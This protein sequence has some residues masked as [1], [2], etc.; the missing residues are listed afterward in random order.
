MAKSFTEIVSQMTKSIKGVREAVLGKEVREHIASGMESEL[1]IY[2]QLNTAVEEVK[3][4]I[5]KA[6]DPTLTLS[7]KA[8]DAK[9]TGA[10]VDKLED[11]KAD[12]TDLDTERKRIDVLNEGGLNLKDEVIDTSIR[13]WLTEHPEAT[14]TVQDGAITEEKIN[15]EFL[16]YIKKRLCYAGNV[17]RNW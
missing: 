9:A 15:T 16:P 13:A 10:A 1:D 8:A 17:W 2:K 3:T 4:A 6:I 14:T 7:G 5:T 11:K 12:K